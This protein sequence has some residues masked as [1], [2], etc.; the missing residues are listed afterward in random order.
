M[1]LP[2]SKTVQGLDVSPWH[3][4]VLEAD[5]GLRLEQGVLDA[6]PCW[7]EKWGSHTDEVKSV[8]HGIKELPSAV[9]NLSHS[10]LVV[11]RCLVSLLTLFGFMSTEMCLC[12][13]LHSEVT[14]KLLLLSDCLP[15]I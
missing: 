8:G 6:C 4:L 5:L 2:L 14:Y 15:H 12:S 9:V 13:S 10:C 11:D 3:G 1:A 7:D